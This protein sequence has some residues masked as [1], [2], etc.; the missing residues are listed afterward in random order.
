M[1]TVGVSTFLAAMLIGS[2]QADVAIS[3][4]AARACAVTVSNEITAAD[5]A[6]VQSLLDCSDVQLW[7]SGPGGDARAAMVIGRWAREREAITAIDSDSHCY[8]SCA[9]IFI[10]GVNRVNLG[11]IGLHRP[12]FAGA[13]L[14][15]PEVARTVRAML[16]DVRNYVEE[17][18]VTSEFANVMVNTPPS[19][20]RVY[21]HEIHSLVPE[22]DPLFDE[23]KVAR[24]ARRYGITTDEYRRREQVTAEFCDIEDLERRGPGDVDPV[25]LFLGCRELMYRGI[26][27]AEYQADSKAAWERCA[28]RAKETLGACWLEVI[29]EP[30]PRRGEPATRAEP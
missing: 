27:Q 29:L 15:E 11:E 5:A 25:A 2:A 7:L 19:E 14:S 4:D 22:T 13:P 20:V 6:R 16:G 1:R 18:G 30:A 8:S 3:R 9:L 17:M 26:S 24:Q 12:Y 10:G 28:G 23:V 21:H